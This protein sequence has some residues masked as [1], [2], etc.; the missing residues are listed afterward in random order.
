MPNIKYHTTG[1]SD[2]EWDG[3]VDHPNSYCHN[4]CS[5]P[6]RYSTVGQEYTRLFFNKFPREARRR[7]L[8]GCYRLHPRIGPY[9]FSEDKRRQVNQPRHN[10]AKVKFHHRASG[11]DCCP[12]KYVY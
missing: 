9:Y 8:D 2:L 1:G 4:Q 12:S 3:R 7:Y 6:G 11:C 10:P 5:L